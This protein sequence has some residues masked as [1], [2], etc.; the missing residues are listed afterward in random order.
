[1]YETLLATVSPDRV[2]IAGDSAGGGLTAAALISLRDRGVPLPA[3][4]VLISP[5]L[6][7]VRDGGVDAGLAARD[8]IVAAE[9]LDTFR[10]WY[11]RDADPREPLASPVL[12]DLRG[13]PP[14]LVQVGSD[15]IVVDDSRRFAARC[16]SAEL[17]V[18]DEM[19]HVWHVFAGRVPEATAAVERI[20]VFLRAHL[21]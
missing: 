7:L 15:E 18:W 8:P 6:D 9:D 4:A 11:L 19:V 1:M 12:A 16:P 5:W 21:A 13:L 20:G 10:R 17:E 2:A 3:A 14:I